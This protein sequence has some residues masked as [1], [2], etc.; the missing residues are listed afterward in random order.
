[1]IPVPQSVLESLAGAI[2]TTSANLSHFAGGRQD[3]DG[4]IYA[5]PYK[6]RRRLL[7]IMAISAQEQRSWLFR[8]EER[9]RF[10]RFLGE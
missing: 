4:V 5:Y 8:L 3:N 10:M 9:M 1:M 2:G 7:K 6:N